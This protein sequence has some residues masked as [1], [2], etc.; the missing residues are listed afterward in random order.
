MIEATTRARSLKVTA[1]AVAWRERDVPVEVPVALVYNGTTYAVMMAS[2][3]DLEDFAIGF[4]LSESIIGAPDD[5]ASIEVLEH[6]NGVELRIWLAEG[7]ARDLVARRRQIIGPTGCGLCGVESLDAVASAFAT[8][9]SD[10]TFD[11]AQIGAAL[12]ALPAAQVLNQQTHAVHGAGFW[13][14]EQGLVAIAEDVGRHNALDKLIGGLR[15]RDIAL[16]RGMILL[17][18]RVSVEMVQKAATAGAPVVV[19]VS[20][21]TGLA[22][23]VAEAAGITLVAVARKDGFEIFTHT[24]RIRCT[25]EVKPQLKERAHHAA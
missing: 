2:P 7:R 24:Q 14:A 5:V 15:R 3:T 10:V 18:S 25:G 22:L 16:S 19:A 17:T 23:K 9:D 1:T 20:A 4:S 21:P 6:D 13:T 12:A 11:A 8:V